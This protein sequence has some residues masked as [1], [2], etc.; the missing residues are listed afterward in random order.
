MP[1]HAAFRLIDP[2]RSPKVTYVTDLPSP[3][4]QNLHGFPNH[5]NKCK[6]MHHDQHDSQDLGSSHD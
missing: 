4:S 2:G 3:I 5:R 6:E 1:E